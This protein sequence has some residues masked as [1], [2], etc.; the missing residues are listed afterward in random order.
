M[1]GDLDCRD[2]TA[3]QGAIIDGTVRVTKLSL[4]GQ[5]SG[6]VEA[7]SVHLGP[8]ARMFGDITYRSLAINEGATFEGSLNRRHTTVDEKVT[9]LRRPN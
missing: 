1:E 2:L 3:G 7:D 9:V 8:T 4:N 6:T 5:I